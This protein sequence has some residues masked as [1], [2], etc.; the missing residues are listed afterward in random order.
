MNTDVSMNT[1]VN[2]NIHMKVKQ[3]IMQEEEQ[4]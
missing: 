4:E 2:I 1:N 3:T